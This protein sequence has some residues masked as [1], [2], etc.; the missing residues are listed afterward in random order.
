[1]ENNG[2][3]PWYVTIWQNES[4]QGRQD[5][6]TERRWQEIWA[7]I[8]TIQV[9]IPT[10]ALSQPLGDWQEIEVSLKDMY[11]SFRGRKLDLPN[12]SKNHIEEI[13]F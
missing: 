3:S 8:K 9:I 11:P 12:F 2:A 1:L 4:K 10:S 13:V 7:T 5:Y 6:Q